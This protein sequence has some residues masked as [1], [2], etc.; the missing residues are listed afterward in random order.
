MSEAYSWP[1]IKFE[2]RMNT[3]KRFTW[4]SGLRPPIARS[5]RLFHAAFIEMLSKL[6]GNPIEIIYIDPKSVTKTVSRYDVSL[7][8]VTVN[9]FGK[10]EDGK[11]DL[12]GYEIDTYGLIYP[13]LK[14]YLK[15]IP[16]DEIPEFNANL[17]YIRT[18]GQPDNCR[19]ASD[20]R[21]KWQEIIGLC[22]QVKQDGYKPQSQLSCGRPLNEVR[23]QISREG[24]YLF[25]DGIH[26]LIIT[27]LLDIQ[28]IPVIVTRVHTDVP[29]ST[30]A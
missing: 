4:L 2:N 13:I 8:S 28:R 9:H 1:Q 19:S 29:S 7:S 27:Q 26:R 25:E 20:Y 6:R 22:E 24:K 15:N 17:A 16:L 12:D 10:I 21:K 30:P 18:G 11:W 23:V 5:Y 14:Q 3:N